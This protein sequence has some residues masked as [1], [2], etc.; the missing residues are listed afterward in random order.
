MPAISDA[1][2]YK[3]FTLIESRPDM[4]QRELANEI[5]VSLGK[6]NYCLNALVEKGF[7]KARNFRSHTD[8]AGYRYLLTPRGFEEKARV[9]FRFL[10]M[11]MAE[12][13]A[14]VAEIKH[15]R[16]DLSSMRGAAELT[17]KAAFTEEDLS[18]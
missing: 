16:H 12:Y 3:L 13:E 2:R 11:K 10:S 7:V 8:K 17:G 1:T 14:L 4:S 15:L 9:T 18:S 5:G 6:V